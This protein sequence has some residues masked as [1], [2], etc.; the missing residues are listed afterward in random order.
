VALGIF[1][2]KPGIEFSS[3]SL[4]TLGFEEEVSTE[5]VKTALAELGYPNAIIQ[6]TGAG[7]IIIRSTVLSGNEKE[8]IELA[9][10]EKFGNLE[11]RGFE[12]IE[13]T[14][15]QQTVRTSIIGVAIAVVAIL[16]Y[17]ALAFRKMPRPFRYGICAIIA[18]LNDVIITLG[19]L[20]FW[21]SFLILRLTSCLLSG[22]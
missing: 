18:L 16:L 19:V 11:E 4:L 15:A 6:T 21:G 8:E 3:G 20:P 5:E 17:M 7:D 10:A 2:L 13:P 22:C 9:L 1:G 12:N 14:I